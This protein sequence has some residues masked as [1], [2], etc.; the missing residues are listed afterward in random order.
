MMD[1]QLVTAVNACYYLKGY[2]IKQD[3]D[4]YHSL[5]ELCGCRYGSC[6]DVTKAWKELGIWE[7]RRFDSWWD[8]IDYLEENGGFFEVSLWHSHYGFHSVAIVD[9]MP[10]AGAARVTNFRQETTVSG[11][12]FLEKLKPH[13]VENPNHEQRCVMR[14]FKEIP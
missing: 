13:L 14:T 10:E 4:Y 7:D 6:I 12:I 3:S 5:A 1:C 11:W 8:G 9:Y 2:A